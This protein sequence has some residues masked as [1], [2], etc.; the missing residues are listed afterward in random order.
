MPYTY[1]PFIR[2]WRDKI[3]PKSTSAKTLG[4][5]I[6]RT[7]YSKL[8]EIF[9]LKDIKYRLPAYTKAFVWYMLYL[10]VNDFPVFLSFRK[11]DPHDAIKLYLPWLATTVFTLILMYFFSLSAFRILVHC[12]LYWDIMLIACLLLGLTCSYFTKYSKTFSCNKNEVVVRT[13]I[14]SQK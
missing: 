5:V 6:Q 11:I 3:R 4:N 9:W 1:A 2:K 10:N 12:A 7:N 14:S 13:F 8:E